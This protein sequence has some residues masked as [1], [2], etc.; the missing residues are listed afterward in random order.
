MEKDGL[1]N[2]ILWLLILFFPPFL[3]SGY[4]NNKMKDKKRVDLIILYVVILNMLFF[5]FFLDYIGKYPVIFN[6]N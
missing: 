1:I 5:R 6:L 2:M 4:L 3:L